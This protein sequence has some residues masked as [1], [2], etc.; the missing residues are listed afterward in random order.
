MDCP[1]C[2]KRPVGLFHSLRPRGLAIKKFF[3]GYFKCK[4]CGTILRQKKESVIFPKFKN[5]FW[6]Y[7]LLFLALIIGLGFG[8]LQLI[9]MFEFQI[10]AVIS[11]ISLYSIII[12][13]IG[14]EL[15]A[16]C[17]IIVEADPEED[18]Q[19][20]EKMT[21]TGVI[22]F[23]LHTLI[24]GA[25]AIWIIRNIEISQVGNFLFF[26]GTFLYLVGVFGVAIW[27]LKKFSMQ[28]AESVS[29]G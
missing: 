1:N 6:I 5:S 12:G 4:N 27:I 17:W 11:L 18:K 23:L 2:G 28:P 24:S 13:G 29:E 10:W 14:D 3:Q 7:Y 16:R 22:I 21:T 15:R 26:I 19:T 20:S 8:V 25:L 9:V